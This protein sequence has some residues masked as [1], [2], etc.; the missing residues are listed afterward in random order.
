MKT[1]SGFVSNSSSASFVVDKAG[2][3][4]LQIALILNHVEAFNLFCKIDEE[5]YY[6]C[7]PCHPEDA[8]AI[9]ETDSTIEGKV[10]MDIFDMR[11]FLR[12]IGVDCQV[13]RG[14]NT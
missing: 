13:D 5:T 11:H 6:G 1:R 12:Y 10:D 3:T 14:H 9:T 7:W 4:P 2:L 8:W